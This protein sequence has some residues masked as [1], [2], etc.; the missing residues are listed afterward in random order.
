M[1]RAAPR[2]IG[3][4]VTWEELLHGRPRARLEGALPSYLARQR[5]FGGK[6][7]AVRRA[8][9]RDAVAV[10]AGD[11][12]TRLAV[13]ALSYRDGAEET[14][15]IPLALAPGAA[16]EGAGADDPALVTTLEVRRE[17]VAVR[18]ADLDPAFPREL[19]AAI[20]EGRT[21]QG[22]GGELAAFST[23]AFARHAEGAEEL[24]PR[25]LGAEQSNTSFRFGDQLVLKLFRRSEPGQNPEVELGVFLTEVARF[26]SAPPVLGAIAYRPRGGEPLSIAL[27]QAFVPNEG[28]AWG[29]ALREVARFLERAGGAAERPPA[30]GRPLLDVAEAPAP[31]SA[32]ERIGAFLDQAAQLGRRTAE[33]HLALASR[34]DLPALRPEP[35]S[36][37]AARSLGDELREHAREVFGLL[38]RRRAKLP[39]AVRAAADRVLASEEELIRR[40]A[41]GLDRPLE[42]LRIRLHG[43]YHLGQVL[44]TGRD[45]VLI[46]FEGEPARSLARRRAKGSPL[47]DVAGMIR[48]FHYAAH[49]GLAAW[50]GAAPDRGGGADEAWGHYWYEC[51]AA[52]F[53]RAYLDEARPG[54]FLPARREELADLLAVYLV[55][56][57]IYELAYELNN[58]PAWVGLPLEGIAGLLGAG[59]RPAG[60]R[61]VTT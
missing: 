40:I 45:F 29:L 8:A 6:A 12:A 37:A 38:R 48:S 32:R 1:A 21:L 60:A 51:V 24:E 42:S 59:A 35:F 2:D 10:R 58:R 17:R 52:A 46:D 11:E 50:R 49:A 27:L 19:L 39:R 55:D 33:L 5:W 43:D 47:K 7:R 34:P 30:T 57:A 4:S 20:R 16:R 15:A 25:P 18:G 31:P 54:G 41:A 13:V 61:E 53:L 44:H 56:K 22:S 26:P 28:D 14:Y 9:I 23:A 36:A 3:N